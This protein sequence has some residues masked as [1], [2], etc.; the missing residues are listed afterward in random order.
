[1]KEKLMV[2]LKFILATLVVTNAFLTIKL[3]D[4]VLR[5]GETILALQK[6][7]TKMNDLSIKTD[8]IHTNTDEVLIQ[9]IIRLIEKVDAGG[10]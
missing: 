4:L 9:A 8:E 6:H 5:Q 1:M 7:Q 3:A 10:L 2:V